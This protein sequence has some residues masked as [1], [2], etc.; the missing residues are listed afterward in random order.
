[1]PV[2]HL[3]FNLNQG[4]ESIA[5]NPAQGRSLELLPQSQQVLPNTSLFAGTHAENIPWLQGTS[6]WNTALQEF[7][8]PQIASRNIIASTLQGRLRRIQRQ[9]DKQARKEQSAPLRALADALQDDADLQSLLQEY[10]N[11]L[12]RA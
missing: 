7:I 9:V 11:A 2:Q 12:M 6:L 3:T 5:P 8:T 10:R 1:M 4:I